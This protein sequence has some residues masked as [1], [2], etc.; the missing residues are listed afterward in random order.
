MG[1][2]AGGVDLG[3]GAEGWGGDQKVSFEH[4]IFEMS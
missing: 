3:A 1:K 4:V 2:A